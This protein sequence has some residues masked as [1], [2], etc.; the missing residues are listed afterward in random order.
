MEYVLIE[1]WLNKFINENENENKKMDI[2]QMNKLVVTKQQQEF[3]LNFL[4]G[5]SDDNCKKRDIIEI[6]QFNIDN[7]SENNYY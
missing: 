5:I 2:N 4:E 6:I 3:V 1:K 7:Y